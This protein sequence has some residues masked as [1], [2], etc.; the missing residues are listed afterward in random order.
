MIIRKI[1]LVAYL[2]ICTPLA[3]LFFWNAHVNNT[4][5]NITTHYLSKFRDISSVHI[6][7]SLTAGG[8]AYWSIRISGKPFDSYNLAGNG[9]TVRQIYSQ[10]AKALKYQPNY[11]VVMGGTNDLF[12]ERFSLAHSINWYQKILADLTKA[13]VGCIITLI[14]YQSNEKKKIAVSSFNKKIREISAG[15]SCKVIDLN[16]TLAPTGVLLEEFTTDGTHFTEA[17]YDAWA[18]EISR[19]IGTM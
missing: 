10:V 9:Y 12:D 7:D 19:V 14:P 3:V 15:Y 5:L 17:A 1:V 8:G 16:K 6:G 13:R 11:V 18:D 2:I 4:V